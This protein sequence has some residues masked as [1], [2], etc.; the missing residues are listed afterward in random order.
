MELVFDPN[1]MKVRM[2]PG[3]LKIDIEI[4]ISQYYYFHRIAFEFYE[5]SMV[6]IESEAN[7]PEFLEVIRNDP[8]LKSTG[9]LSTLLP[10]NIKSAIDDDDI[11][12]S[13]NTIILQEPSKN[14]SI[15]KLIDEYGLDYDGTNEIIRLTHK[16]I[17]ILYDY[18]Q[19]FKNYF[20]SKVTHEGG[21]T[22]EAKYDDIFD[23]D[24]LTSC[25]GCSPSPT[26]EQVSFLQRCCGFRARLDTDYRPLEDYSTLCS[27][28][29]LPPYLE[30]HSGQLQYLDLLDL[31][32]NPDLIKYLYS[33]KMASS[34]ENYDIFT[35]EDL[36]RLFMDDK[37]DR[38]NKLKDILKIEKDID[39]N[40]YELI[41]YS[42]MLTKYLD[43][44]TAGGGA[45]GC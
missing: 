17:A 22:I 5:L 37:P 2:F 4:N 26:V 23:F 30:G 42:R 13:E 35:R 3:K 1:P 14:K 39:I 38:Y 25:A 18:Y 19:E 44:H 8:R 16:N 34:P 32:Y 20:G 15:K 45:A 41:L 36:N 9:D 29:Q 7:I 12:H 11:K 24:M 6:H 27:S 28:E 21:V 31:L 43:R 33:V 10:P 40:I